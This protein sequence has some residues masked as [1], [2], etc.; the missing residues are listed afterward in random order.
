MITAVTAFRACEI[1]RRAKS[2]GF[3]FLYPDINVSCAIAYPEKE[4]NDRCIGF[5]LSTCEGG[6]FTG[7]TREET[8][9]A[10]QHDQ[11]E[12]LARNRCAVGGRWPRIGA[13]YAR[14]S[15]RSRQRA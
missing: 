10:T 6:G 9:N 4:R 5:F 1:R 11:K 12:V 3:W 14:R 2:S 15:R 13:R 7:T 8:Y